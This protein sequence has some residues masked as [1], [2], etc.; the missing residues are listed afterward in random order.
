MQARVPGAGVDVSALIFT[1]MKTSGIISLLLGSI[2][3]S[4]CV[5]RHSAANTPNPVLNCPPNEECGTA[6]AWQPPVTVTPSS[7]VVRTPTPALPAP[8][9]PHYF[10]SL[11]GSD[12]NPG[13]KAA[14]FRS[15]GKAAAVARAGDVVLIE[16]GIYYEDVKPQNSGEP[17]KYIIYQ[18]EGEG[19]VI[20][21]AQD[22]QRPA[23]IEIDNKSYLQ[24]SG[25]TVRG[26][27]SYETWPRAGIAMTDGTNHIILDNITAYGNFVGIMAYGRENPV[28]FITVQNSKTFGPGNVGNIHYGIFF[29]KKVYDSSIVNNHVAFTLPAGRRVMV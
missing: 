23:C 8:S 25:L 12:A 24:F 19:Q 10:V 13:T 22:G 15:I 29:Y 17:G 2:I 4:A 28:S 1:T 6:A 16:P 14:A 9:S 27:N 3:L 5:T 21:D 20:I 7:I 11:R 26:A 18:K